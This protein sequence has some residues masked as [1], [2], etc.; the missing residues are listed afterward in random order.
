MPK[1]YQKYQN[2]S[3]KKSIEIFEPRK[4]GLLQGDFSIFFALL[5]WSASYTR[6]KS[7]V[8]SSVAHPS[9]PKTPSIP[10]FFRR[11]LYD[12]DFIRIHP[13]SLPSKKGRSRTRQAP[14]GAAGGIRSLRKYK[15]ASSPPDAMKVFKQVV[16]MLAEER[17]EY[18]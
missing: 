17:P 4:T 12:F 6:K 9:F 3:N 5:F 8:K 16:P 2:V 7:E 13:T 10:P 15:K 11:R 18:F 1:I 14:S